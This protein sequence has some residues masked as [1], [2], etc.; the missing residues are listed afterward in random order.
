MRSVSVVAIVS[1]IALVN[2]QNTEA[3]RDNYYDNESPAIWVDILFLIIIIIHHIEY[4]FKFT[5]YSLSHL[6]V[7]H[8]SREHTPNSNEIKSIT[9][10][11]Q[12]MINT[13]FIRYRTRTN[14]QRR[15]HHNS[16]CCCIRFA[17][18]Y[19]TWQKTYLIRT[20]FK[21]YFSASLILALVLYTEFFVNL[22]IEYFITCIVHYD[23]GYIFAL[24]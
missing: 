2:G 13:S 5:D 21:L 20:F 7:I 22:L 24:I 19:F 18:Q 11:I 12:V 15:F 14:P 9:D 17:P 8:Q 1:L 3:G 23:K 4:A 6:H 10:L 16:I